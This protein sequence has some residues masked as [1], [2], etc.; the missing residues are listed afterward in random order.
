MQL[1]A[2]L[3]RSSSVWKAAGSMTSVMSASCRGLE[4]GREGG[5][6]VQGEAT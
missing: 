6:A 4:G 5:E 1:S 3:C 2:S